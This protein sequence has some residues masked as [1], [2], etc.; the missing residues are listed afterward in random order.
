MQQFKELQEK[1]QNQKQKLTKECNEIANDKSKCQESISSCTAKLQTISDQISCMQDLSGERFEKVRDIC[2]KLNIP[3][4]DLDQSVDT[5]Q[6]DGTFESIKEKIDEEE[7]GVNF[8]KVEAD[9]IDRGH[10]KK[11]DKLREER[12][13]LETE[14]DSLKKFI[15]ST[16]DSRAKIKEEIQV[17]ER[18]IPALNQLKPKIV[19]AEK[20]LEE[21]KNDEKRIQGILLLN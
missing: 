9:E 8:M 17:S 13:K 11:I 2:E 3:F 18:S 10:Q 1:K 7:E 15:E 21:L 19:Q 16:E 12:T 14:I 4:N 6:V 5:Q 20:K